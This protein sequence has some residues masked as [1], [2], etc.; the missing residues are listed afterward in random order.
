M[1][2]SRTLSWALLSY[3][4]H[5]LV[6]STINNCYTFQLFYSMCLWRCKCVSNPSSSNLTLSFW[7]IFTLFMSVYLIWITSHF[8]FLICI[9]VSTFELKWYVNIKVDIKL[10]SHRLSNDEGLAERS[11]CTKIRI[12]GPGVKYFY[13]LSC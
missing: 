5:A 9:K 4:F 10:C 6:L 2:F 8:I 1:K 11:P 3:N 7:I 12:L 13:L